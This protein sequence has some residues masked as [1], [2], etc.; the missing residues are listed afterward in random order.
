LVTRLSDICDTAFAFAPHIKNELINRRSLSSAAARAR[1]LV[2]EGLAGAVDQPSMGLDNGGTPPELAIY[3]S[4]IKAGNVHVERGGRYFVQVPDIDEDKLRLRPAL[5]HIGKV[6]QSSGDRPVAYNDIVKE[7][8]GGKFGIRDGLIPLLIAIYIAAN[9]HRTAVYEDGTYLDQVG[10]PEFNRIVKEPEFFQ[11]Q[12]CAIEG[13]RAEVFARLST[14]IGLP[15]TA[16]VP[17]LL[18]VVRPLVTFV[19]R[20]PDHARRT[21]QLS[22]STVSARTAL[23][24]G[25]DP[26]SLIFRD[27]PRSFG[28]EAIEF[29]EKLNESLVDGFV[30]ATA[31][32]IRELREAY[33]ALLKRIT[34]SLGAAVDC[35][36]SIDVLRPELINRAERVKASL[37]EP[38]LKAFVLRLADRGLEDQLW[39]ES[40]ASLVAKKPPERWAD[41]D[42]ADF[43]HRLPLLARRF[44]HVEATR[45][46]EK[47][48][49]GTTAYRLLVTSADGHETE[50]VYRASPGEEKQLKS[51][52][53]EL[54]ELLARNGR[55]GRLA[56]ARVLLE[57][58][59][60]EKE[61]E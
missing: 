8:R 55:I 9:W 46:P 50:R 15:A 12:Y 31:G 20:L 60:D 35:D 53:A 10:G 16:D 11:L 17:D 2:I 7:L 47:Q 26:T 59:R 25:V 13:V 57:L 40:I 48:E 58:E 38:E 27:L 23:I 42:E 61:S 51:A 4:V 18:D 49:S 28:F 32:A 6:L 36:S 3:L 45:F 54:R 22:A 21:R 1:F 24:G 5:L 33:P 29:G 34:R 19:A 52:E 39:L 43:H 41:S 14:A 44:K 37:T 56:A 30:R